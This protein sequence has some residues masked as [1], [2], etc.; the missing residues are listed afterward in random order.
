MT[1]VQG[2]SDDLIIITH[3][4]KEIEFTPIFPRMKTRIGFSD[5]SLIEIY[6][7]HKNIWTITQLIRGYIAAE[8][9]ACNRS[10][11]SDLYR[12]L[13]DPDRI[14]YAGMNGTERII[15]LNKEV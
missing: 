1:T 11:E 8:I 4:E 15:R 7:D 13:A 12:T 10:D 3:N 6:C 2:M 5:G 9:Y 14:E